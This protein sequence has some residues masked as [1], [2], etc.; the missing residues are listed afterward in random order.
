MKPDTPKKRRANP[1][2]R[3]LLEIREYQRSTNLLIP[4]LP[5]S[6]LVREIAISICGASMPDC[7][8]T[9]T[10]L[11]ALQEASE[12]YLT[13]LLE[14]ANLCAIHGKRVTIMPEDLRLAMRVHGDR[15]F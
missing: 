4:K 7:R 5:F 6:R 12:E 1:G 13:M 15:L 9:A 3:A 14:D 2:T 10:S 8:F 11:M